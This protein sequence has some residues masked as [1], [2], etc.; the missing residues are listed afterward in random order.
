MEGCAGGVQTTC[1]R[2]RRLSGPC[3][4]TLWSWSVDDFTHT[5]SPRRSACSR[6][7]MPQ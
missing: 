4:E 2:I 3:T 5:R 7:Q 1:E 6:S